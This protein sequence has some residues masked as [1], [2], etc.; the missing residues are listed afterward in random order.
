MSICTNITLCEI[1]RYLVTSYVTLHYTVLYS[2]D[3]IWLRVG[4]VIVFE[5]AREVDMILI[6]IDSVLGIVSEQCLSLV[7][8]AGCIRQADRLTTL[9]CVYLGGYVVI[10]TRV[11][12][13]VEKVVFV[14][15]VVY[16]MMASCS[17]AG[18]CDVWDNRV[19][20]ENLGMM[21]LRLGNCE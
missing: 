18:V 5:Y 9:F 8:R 21:Y 10:I 12:F 16:G 3:F 13:F 7:L 17:I 11:Y 6:L 15:N 2:L 4:H 19:G 14:W 20:I 1:L